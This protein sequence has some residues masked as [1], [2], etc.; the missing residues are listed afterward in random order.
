PAQFWDFEVYC[1]ETKQTTK[2]STGSGT[3]RQYWPL[4]EAI[5][6]GM[7]AVDSPG[8]RIQEETLAG[9]PIKQVVA[10]EPVLEQIAKRELGVETLATR[11]SDQLDFYDLN[12]ASMKTAL[13][14]AYEAGTRQG[15]GQKM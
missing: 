2:F 4:A 3:F 7:V 6:Q 1:A 14:K 9:L 11:N 5:A 13:L 10:A 8:N 12:V 15:G